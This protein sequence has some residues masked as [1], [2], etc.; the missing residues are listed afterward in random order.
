MVWTL[1]VPLSEA[2]LDVRLKNI[3]N[4]S[5]F[6]CGDSLL[7]I[8]SGINLVL[9]YDL[10]PTAEEYIHRVGRTGRM[11]RAGQAITY[12]ADRSEAEMSRLES[13]R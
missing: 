10:P 12:Y 9:N 4:S 3:L 2:I 5:F 6:R 13:S 7:L 11:G 1:T 8:N